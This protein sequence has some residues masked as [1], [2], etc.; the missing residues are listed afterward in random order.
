MAA[1]NARFA[2]I[3][4]EV[5]AVVGAPVELTIR[6]EQSFTFSTETMNAELGDKV[7]TFFGPYASVTCDHDA[8]CGSFAYV[9]IEAAR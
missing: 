8:E 1:L 2:K 9:E 4:T 5:S 7:A 6:G 3:E